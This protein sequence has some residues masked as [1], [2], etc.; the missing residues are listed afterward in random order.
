MKHLFYLF[1]F[2]IVAA[3]IVGCKEKTKK[4]VV[5]PIMVT[6]E[7]QQNNAVDSTIYGK[8]CEATT[9][10]T[11]YIVDAKG[12]TLDFLI[13]DEANVFGGKLVG[14]KMAV[15]SKEVYGENVAEKVINI[16]SLMGRWR[17]IDRD[18][19]IKDGGVIE[20]YQQ[21]ETKTFT[22][23]SIF[24]GH[25]ILAPDTFDINLLGPDSMR[26][27]NKNYIYSF[28]RVDMK[29]EGN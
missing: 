23:W 7:N 12:D 9:M 26:L 18:F 8:C 24:N 10:N 16:M 19:A 14:D 2:F 6:Q 21:A 11:L 29:N 4:N 25:L 17:S 27:E 20:S 1:V 5:K 3:I 13:E 28:E 15:I 22:Q